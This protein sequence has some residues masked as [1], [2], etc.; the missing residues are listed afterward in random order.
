MRRLPCFGS[1]DGVAAEVTVCNLVLMGAEGVGKSAI[2]QQFL[3]G[4][5]RQAY[6]PTSLE[7]FVRCETVS[8]ELY[9]IHL[10][11]CSG[12]SGFS[13]H[14]APYIAEAHGLMFIYSTTD[15][16]S[17]L[18]LLECARES[19]RARQQH[20][21]KG[22]IPL[23]LVGTRADDTEHHVVTVQD[24]ERV[25]REC[26]LTLGVRLSK[27]CN[28][29]ENNGI[30]SGASNAGRHS[31]LPVL[32]ISSRN[33]KDV[34]RAMHL[35][36]RM[37]H[38]FRIASSPPGVTLNCPK[39]EPRRLVSEELN[40][41]TR[42]GNAGGDASPHSRFTVTTTTISLPTVS[43]NCLSPLLLSDS[44]VTASYSPKSVGVTQSVFS[45]AAEDEGTIEQLYLQESVGS[46][47]IVHLPPWLLADEPANVLASDTTPMTLLASEELSEKRASKMGPGQRHCHAC[48]VM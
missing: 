39:V 45:S 43:R 42:P 3:K 38:Y 2:L 21:V 28:K 17:L 34:L 6:V 25:V 32:E 1:R 41:G 33:H 47:V 27:K 44:D 31:D 37:A 29:T 36:I 40:L 16:D 30:G 13:E 5:F 7:T 48:H 10:C 14:R 8:G 35:M 18:C 24:A 4:T 15:M 46:E 20:G 26:L 22:S 19:C 9:R 23:L 12:S 11:D